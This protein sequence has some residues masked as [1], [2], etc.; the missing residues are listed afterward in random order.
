[1]WCCLM[2][3]TLTKNALLAYIPEGMVAPYAG[4]HLNVALP[5][6]Q[7][8]QGDATIDTL[9]GDL[10]HSNDPLL[11]RYYSS[12]RRRFYE[13][14]YS[15]NPLLR[16][17]YCR[18]IRGAQI[19]ASATRRAKIAQ[20]ALQGMEVLV[21]VYPKI[22]KQSFFISRFQFNLSRKWVHLNDGAPVEV[23]CDLVDGVHPHLYAQKS[24]TADPAARLGIYVE[25]TDSSGKAF[26]GWLQTNGEKT[27]FAMNTFVDLLE[28][29]DLETS[30]KRTR[31]WVP[32]PTP[33]RRR[34]R[35][36]DAKP[37]YTS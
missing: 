8:L 9:H 7:S 6:H 29:V 11:Q 24:G 25:G 17:Y 28:G 35:S 36:D 13:L 5:I 34:H 18:T 10:Y 19:K 14:K 21:D 22:F 4:M 1:M 37:Y 16:E 31:R 27:V 32:Y 26:R 12:L 20:A 2:L 15:P 33:G 23:R 30:M 3:Q